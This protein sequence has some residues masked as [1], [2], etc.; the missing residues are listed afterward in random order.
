MTSV[1]FDRRLRTA[2]TQDYFIFYLAIPAAVALFFASFGSRLT[3][4]MPFF[5]SGL[6]MLLHV[7]GAWWGIGLGSYLINR[8]FASWQ[9]P[10]YVNMVIGFFLMLV[11]LTFYLKA[12][13]EFFVV[14]FPSFE[15]ASQDDFAPSW[16]IGY[17]LY[18]IRYSLPA[19]PL[20]MAA[21]YGYRYVKGVDWYGYAIVPIDESQILQQTTSKEE[22]KASP[23]AALLTGTKLPASAVLYAI[24]AEEHYIHI[25]SDQGT[26]LIR[27]RFTDIVEDLS[28]YYGMQVHRSWWVNTEYVEKNRKKGRSLELELA[29]D[30]QVPVSLAYK[31]A[32]SNAL[33]ITDAT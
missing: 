6:Y 11:P 2:S 25:W 27:Y 19:L 29:N 28:A 10:S 21:V 23:T 12:L 1:T 9:P 31:Q 22:P 24:K 18:Y 26:D 3:V 14:N 7:L 20:F 8:L 16:S 33:N 13:G 32:V 17:L 15:A 30:L 4:G 5:D